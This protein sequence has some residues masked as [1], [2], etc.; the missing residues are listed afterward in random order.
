MDRKSRPE[1]QTALRHALVDY[2]RA[3]LISTVKL[4]QE[5]KGSRHDSQHSLSTPVLKMLRGLA[6]LEFE[7]FTQYA[8]AKMIQRY[9]FPQFC[10]ETLEACGE[11]L[12]RQGAE[13]VMVRDF[14]VAGASQEMLQ[15]LFGLRRTEVTALRSNLNITLKSGRPRKPD[16]DN[17][18]KVMNVWHGLP[19]ELDD[20]LRLYL[21]YLE[22]D[23]SINDAWE[24]VKKQVPRLN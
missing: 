2:V 15:R 10:M 7:E 14:G 1:A 21:T 6:V 12:M 5:G 18:S 4:Y 22:A 17:D 9:R 8:V 24:V 13:T 11:M 20:R 16:P 19:S 23:V 3:Y